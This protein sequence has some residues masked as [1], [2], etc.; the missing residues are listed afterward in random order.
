MSR[1]ICATS[2]PGFH[3]VPLAALRVGILAA[4]WRSSS[5]PWSIRPTS[6]ARRRSPAPSP[7]ACS[8]ERSPSGTDGCSATGSCGRTRESR[9]RDHPVT[10]PGCTRHRRRRRAAARSASAALC[11]LMTNLLARR[12]CGAAL[13]SARPAPVC[14]G[15]EDADHVVA[16]P[17]IERDPALAHEHRE[18]RR[19]RRRY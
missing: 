7:P 1:G 2:G 9:A 14:V 4:R 8:G 16:E 10:A 19:R 12:P 11:R 15:H 18:E 6:R 3:V 13:R 17:G 5:F